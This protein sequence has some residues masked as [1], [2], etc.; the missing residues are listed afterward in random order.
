MMYCGHSHGGDVSHIPVTT[1][2]L[3]SRHGQSLL[4]ILAGDVSKGIL[5]GKRLRKQEVQYG[6]FERSTAGVWGLCL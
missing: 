5:I 1:A 3:L 4:S 6:L 2:S